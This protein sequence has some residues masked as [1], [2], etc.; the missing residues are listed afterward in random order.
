MGESNMRS[1]VKAAV[2]GALLLA[3]VLT[4]CA[5]TSTGTGSDPNNPNQVEVFTW[6]SAGSEKLG[7]DA[8]VGVFNKDHPNI[9]FIN[10]A[11]TGG[12]GT[13]AKKALAF[14]LKAKNPPDTFQAHAGAELTDYIKAGQLQDL[15]SF[16]QQ[17]GLDKVFPATLLKRL[18]V[19]GKIYS[20]PSN[21]HRANV[22]WANSAVLKAAGIDPA[23]PPVDL[24]GWIAQ[25]QAV[26][27]TGVAAPLALGTDWT[28]VQLFENC[29]IADLGADAYSGLWDGST[30]WDDPRVA[31]AV[32]HFG[33]LLTFTNSNADSLDWDKAT[34]LVIDGTAAYNVMGDWAEANFTQQGKVYGTDYAA[35]PTP[36]TQGVFDFLADSFTLP[37]GAPHEDAAR[38]WLKVISSPAGQKA[39]NLAKGSIPSRTDANASDYPA[40]QQTAITSFDDDTIV[41]SLTHGAAAK[42]TWLADITTAVAGFVKDHKTSAFETALTNAADSAL[43]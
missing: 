13:N 30:K 25:L 23:T 15:S 40:Y 7:L 35:F 24:D 43:K 14:R 26:K 18:T 2:I 42:S 32:D 8:L 9:E 39:F 17:N 33:K 29:L 3:L 12:A 34:Q 31:T 16:Y 38:A 19:K 22:V 20:V 4:G 5:T 41:S 28:Q 10:A 6:W 36:G 27:D 21:I 1:R 37:V 11:V